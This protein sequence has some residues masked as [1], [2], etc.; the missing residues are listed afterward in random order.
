MLHTPHGAIATPVFMPVGTRATVKMMTPADLRKLGAQIILGNTYHL[1]LR[2]GG[3]IIAAHGGLHRFMGW[4]GPILT[5][6]GGF[7]VFS[8]ADLR[9][10]TDEGVRFRSHIDGSPLFLGPREAMAM[11][12]LLGADIIMAFDECPPS[13]A[14]RDVIAQAVARTARW[15]R[16]CLETHRENRAYDGQQLFGIIQ[17]GI[18]DDLRCEHLALFTT[19]PFDGYAIGGLAV[20]EAADEMYRIT[21]L[22][23]RQLPTDKPRYLMGVGRPDDIV[24]AVLRGVDMFDCVMPTRNARNGS[25]FTSTGDLALK[26]GKYKDDLQPVQSDCQCY[27]CRNF[28]RAYIRHLFNVGEPLGGHLLTVH[29]THFYLTLMRALREAIYANRLA[30]FAHDFLARRAGGAARVAVTEPENSTA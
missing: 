17:G 7:Q 19:L 9:D 27:T 11:Q 26:S 12:H 15:G 8:L 1:S 4:D 14:P 18:H 30:D 20:G 22:C 24:Q 28:T 2:P 21:D 5:D 29:N 13:T 10:I 25:A 23:C 3:G 16:M 6:S